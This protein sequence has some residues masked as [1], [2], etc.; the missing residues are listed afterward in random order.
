MQEFN[1]HSSHWALTNVVFFGDNLNGTH[2]TAFPY[3]YGIWKLDSQ[4]QACAMWPMGWLVLQDD[5][6]W[7]TDSA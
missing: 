3:V 1:H 4:R 7:D 5:D 6:K 2:I